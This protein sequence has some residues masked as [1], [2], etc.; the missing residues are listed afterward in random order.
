MDRLDTPLVFGIYPLLTDCIC[1]SIVPTSMV[2]GPQRLCDCI[3][4]HTEF[5]QQCYEWN[6]M[7]HC[8]GL[9]VTISTDS[10]NSSYNWLTF[11]FVLLKGGQ[12]KRQNMTTYIQWMA[13]VKHSRCDLTLMHNISA[14]TS[15]QLDSRCQFY[16]QLADQLATDLIS[17]CLTSSQKAT[18]DQLPRRRLAA[19]WRFFR[20]TTGN[21]QL[22]EFATDNC[23]VFSDQC[24]NDT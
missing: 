24:Q 8:N 22:G 17:V 20:M 6:A 18:E 3:I 11:F 13:V 10:S 4:F 1:R 7:G 5:F 23:P 2:Y 19:N 16:C 14:I 21:R 15:M 9:L 12:K